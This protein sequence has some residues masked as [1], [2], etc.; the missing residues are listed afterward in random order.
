MALQLKYFVLNPNKD[1]PYGEASRKALDQYARAINHHDP[2][3]A[4]DIEEWVRRI[5][6]EL[7]IR[8]TVLEILRENFKM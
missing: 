8:K 2:E 5:R 7:N 1:N 4:Q 3:L 6:R